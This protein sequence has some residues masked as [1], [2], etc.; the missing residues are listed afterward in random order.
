VNGADV[1]PSL[2]T[3][4]AGAAALGVD[5]LI[6]QLCGGAYLLWRRGVPQQLCQLFGELGGGRAYQRVNPLLHPIH[7]FGGA[8]IGKGQA[9]QPMRRHPPAAGRDNRSTNTLV[10]PVPADAASQTLVWGLAA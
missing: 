3:L 5:N 6:Q 4:T 9:Q 10:L 7:H 1:H 2:P 8:N